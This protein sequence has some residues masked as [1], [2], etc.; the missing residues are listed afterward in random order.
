MPSTPVS[1]Y[2]QTPWLQAGPGPESFWRPQG[3]THH[4]LSAARSHLATTW[5]HRYGSRSSSGD[6]NN[7]RHTGVPGY[8]GVLHKVH[9]GPR[10]QPAPIPKPEGQLKSRPAAKFFSIPE[11]ALS[12]PPQVSAYRQGLRSHLLVLQWGCQ[13]YTRL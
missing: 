7:H 6:R 9:I 4:L 8:K 13:G 11:I 10:H 3:P 12:F 1:L 5:P 2:L